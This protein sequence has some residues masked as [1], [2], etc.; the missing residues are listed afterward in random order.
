M[1]KTKIM[2]VEDEGIIATDIKMALQSAGYHVCAVVSTGEK[3]ITLAETEKPELIIMDVKLA[4]KL[5]GIEAGNEIRSRFNIPF[6]YLTAHSDAPLL[7]K[8]CKNRPF[9]YFK[10]PFNEMDL[11]STIESIVKNKSIL[12]E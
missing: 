8:M 4:G 7:D 2:V 1:T 3:A 6:I 10:K 11:L 12:D 5:D 9:I